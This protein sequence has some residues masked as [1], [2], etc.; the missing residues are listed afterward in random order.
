MPLNMNNNSNGI[1]DELSEIRA[2]IVYRN[3]KVDELIMDIA[4]EMKMLMML[5]KEQK[6]LRRYKAK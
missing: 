6:L 5:P 3:D 2:E 1:S 4:D